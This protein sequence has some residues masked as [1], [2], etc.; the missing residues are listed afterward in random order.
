M[1]ARE[2]SRRQWL[3]M[4][5]SSSS[6][7]LYHRPNTG[8]IKL[9]PR[10]VHLKKTRG[11][12]IVRFA[13]RCLAVFPQRHGHLLPALLRCAGNGKPAQNPHEKFRHF[14]SLRPAPVSSNIFVASHDT[15]IACT[16]P[17]VAPST[18]TSALISNITKQ[19]SSARITGTAVSRQ[20]FTRSAHA[21]FVVHFSLTQQCLAHNTK[22]TTSSQR[23]ACQE[24]LP[25]SQTNCESH[26][27]ISP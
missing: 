27:T 3:F 8:N 17:G 24:P 6:H 14:D 9:Q 18:T 11:T 23:H 16:T 12:L 25:S 19:L 1:P 2:P 21:L 13:F 22:L 20:C 7:S 5:T 26:C 10:I 15:F 4:H